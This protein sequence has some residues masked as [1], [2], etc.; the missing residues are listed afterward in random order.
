VDGVDLVVNATSEREAVLV[1]LGPGQTLIDLPYPAT[2]T[3][4]EAELRGADVVDGLEVLVAQGAASFEAWTGIPAPL[5]VMRAAV[6][7][8]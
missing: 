3:A 6:R 8:R 1:E 7:R 4:R 2:A 5:D